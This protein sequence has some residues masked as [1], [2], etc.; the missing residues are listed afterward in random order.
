MNVTNC[1]DVYVRLISFKLFFSH[2]SVSPAG[3]LLINPKKLLAQGYV[4]PQLHCAR[5]AILYTRS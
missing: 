1:A 2:L 3:I 5:D 4:H